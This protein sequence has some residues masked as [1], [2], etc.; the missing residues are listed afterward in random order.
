MSLLLDCMVPSEIRLSCIFTLHVL[1]KSSILSI[2]YITVTGIAIAMAFGSVVA[3]LWYGA[4]SVLSGELSPGTLGQF[5]LYSVFAAGSL[6]INST[7]FFAFPPRR[8]VIGRLTMHFRA[9]MAS[10][11]PRRT[12]RTSPGC[13]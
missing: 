6:G 12:T 5:L 11:P 8:A 4:Q 3:V 9:V 13:E 2:V 7:R 10:F 1:C